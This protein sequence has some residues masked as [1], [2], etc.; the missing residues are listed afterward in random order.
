[1]RRAME[2]LAQ[3]FLCLFGAGL[4]TILWEDTI[5]PSATLFVFPVLMIAVSL[6]RER[7]KKRQWERRLARRFTEQRHTDIS[8]WQPSASR[9]TTEAAA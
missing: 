7:R 3:A 6:W 2:D 9:Q 1:M 8:L 5:G 4:P